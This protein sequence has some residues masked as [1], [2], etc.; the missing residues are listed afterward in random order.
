MMLPENNGIFDHGGLAGL[1]DDDHTQYHNNT[2]GDARYFQQSEFLVTSAGAGDSGKPVKLDA[3]GHIDATMINDGDVDHGALAGLGDDDHSQYI[4]VDGTRA[5]TGNQSF[6]NNDLID[7]DKIGINLA[8]P[9]WDLDIMRESTLPVAQMTTHSNT[10]GDRAILFMRKSGG[11]AASPSATLTNHL[12][13]SWTVQGH[14][15]GAFATGGNL[16]FTATE[17]W[18][19][20]AWGTSFSFQGTITGTTTRADWLTGKDS[21]IGINETDP[22]AF[23][24][25]VSTNL[26]IPLLKVKGVSGQATDYIT[27]VN[28]I[29]TPGFRVTSNFD[30]IIGTAAA[31]TDYTLTFNGESNQGIITWLE[32][33]DMFQLENVI[34]ETANKSYFRDTAIGVYSQS[35]TFLDL[36]ADGA[37][38]IG[39]SSAGAPTAYTKIEPD[40][41]LHFVG[42]GSGKVFGVM[43]IP[44][45]DIVVSISDANPTEIK[46]DGTTSLNDG[47][48]VGELNEVTFPTGGTEHYLTVPEAGKYTVMWSLSGHTGSGGST[49]IHAGVMIDGVALRDEGE[50]HR[51]VSNFN[52]NGN[53]ASVVVIDCPNGTEQISLFCAVGNSNDF[54][55]VHGTVVIEQIAGT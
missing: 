4:L 17:N 41:G 45:T 35:D 2:R 33:E 25:I 31:G 48:S 8:S 5:F 37:V 16:F 22:D 26:G 7:V 30:V 10:A 12:L 28:F 51:D 24:E 9:V 42:T 21:M 34:F 11:S 38:R 47:W 15:G 27:A 54:H 43:Y 44:G 55:A 40:G 52:D 36:F 19:G 18:G 50:A 46:D 1:L 32:D 14:T 6:G 13:G 29:E 39:N 3:A 20:A 53:V 23:L 49:T